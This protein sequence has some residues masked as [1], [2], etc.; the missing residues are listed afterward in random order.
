MPSGKSR[1]RRRSSRQT[2]I[3]IAVGSGLVIITVLAWQATSDSAYLKSQIA[4]GG[5]CYSTTRTGGPVT[6]IQTPGAGECREDLTYDLVEIDPDAGVPLQQD[7]PPYTFVDGEICQPT[8]DLCLL[9][10]K[11]EETYQLRPRLPR[12]PSATRQPGFSIT[13]DRSHYRQELLA[14]ANR[15]RSQC[16]TELN[17]QQCNCPAGYESELL[18]WSMDDHAVNLP[19][20]HDP[21]D[22]GTGSATSWRDSGTVVATCATLGRC[23]PKPKV[24]ATP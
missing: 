16:Y 13:Y 23:V 17:Q 18:T 8:N 10:S 22:P 24:S 5:A 12:R 20:P 2:W 19:A 1:Q 4:R 15:V 21:N 3:L 9:G 6:C 14:I 7:L 11:K